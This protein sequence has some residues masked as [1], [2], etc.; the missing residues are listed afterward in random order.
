MYGIQHK[1]NELKRKKNIHKNI[2]KP[3]AIRE[4][5]LLIVEETVLVEVVIVG[6]HH[7]HH[8]YT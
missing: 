3:N 5:L 2:F 7:H 1:R 8:H 4:H 6:G